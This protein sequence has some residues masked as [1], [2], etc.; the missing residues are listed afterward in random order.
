MWGYQRVRGDPPECNQMYIITVFWFC[1]VL[2]LVLHVWLY[3]GLIRAATEVVGVHTEL[4]WPEESNGASNL[5]FRMQFGHKSWKKPSFTHS[6][7]WE[8][9]LLQNSYG[10]SQLTY[11]SCP[12]D[13]NDTHF[14]IRFTQKYGKTENKKN[15][16]TLTLKLLACLFPIGESHNL[17]YRWTL[18]VLDY[19]TQGSNSFQM[20]LW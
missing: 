17:V 8:P 7:N 10:Y 11:L 2:E 13:S 5:V 18:A 16:V 9:G 6:I 15:L 14:C 12:K 4:A 1:L 19:I 3:C 20:F